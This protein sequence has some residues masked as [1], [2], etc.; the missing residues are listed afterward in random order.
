MSVSS[1]LDRFR[2]VLARKRPAVQE[3]TPDQF[4]GEHGPSMFFV[5]RLQAGDSVGAEIPDGS[6]LNLCSV[7]LPAFV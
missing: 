4:M 6:I 1:L 2:A 5:G 7:M 3:I